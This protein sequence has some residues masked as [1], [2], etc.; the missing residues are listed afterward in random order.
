MVAWGWACAAAGVVT[1][2]QFIRLL[3]CGV[4]N[5]FSPSKIYFLEKYFVPNR[6]PTHNR[7]GLQI[8]RCNTH[9][10]WKYIAH[11]YAGDESPPPH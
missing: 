10:K 5:M 11:I 4:L 8:V 6:N 9:R 3:S 2:P 1:P 7:R